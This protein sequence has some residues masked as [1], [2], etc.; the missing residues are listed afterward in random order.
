MTSG[1]SWRTILRRSPGRA[2]ARSRYSS[3]NSRHL[4]SEFVLRFLAK[5]TATRLHHALIQT[6]AAAQWLSRQQCLSSGVQH[7]DRGRRWDGAFA[8]RWKL[9]C[10]KQE[11]KADADEIKP[12]DIVHSWCCLLHPL[13]RQDQH[14][15]QRHLQQYLILHALWVA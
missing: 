1:S 7:C 3:D 13:K 10:C 14:L 4:E 5:I 11:T 2:P 12:Q 8:W 9:V 15:V 6:L